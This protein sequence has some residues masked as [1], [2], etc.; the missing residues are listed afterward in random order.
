[1]GITLR[2]ASISFSQLR[3]YT[4][5]ECTEGVLPLG[6]PEGPGEERTAS[7]EMLFQLVMLLLLFEREMVSVPSEP[8][9]RMLLLSSWLRSD[10]D[11]WAP[12]VG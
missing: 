3:P 10:D 5:V 8:D 4:E 7:R 9:P 1:M 6:I 11:T 2:R 12:A